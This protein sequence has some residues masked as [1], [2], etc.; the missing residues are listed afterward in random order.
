[1]FQDFRVAYLRRHV[2][3]REEL[4]LSFL[5]QSV[6]YL[7]SHSAKRIPH[8]AGITHFDVTNLVEYGEEQE[9]LS[10]LDDKALYK[11]SLRK[12]FSAFFLKAIAHGLHHVPT[13]NGFLDY[14]FIRNG[15]TLY[16]AEDVN[17][18][19][20]VHT[21]HGVVRP[22]LRNAHQ[23]DLQT[24]AGEMRDLTRRAR[25]TDP[26]WLY[27][28]AARIYAREAVRQ[29]DL[30]A[31]GGLW[32]LARSVF[33]SPKPD[34]ADTPEEKRLKPEE[35]LGSTS[36]LANIGMMVTGHQT[37]T[38]I[39]PPEVTMFGIGDLH[40]APRVVDGEVVPRWTITLCAT[41]DHRAFDAGE[42][43]PMYQHLKRYFENPS[44]I[45]DWKP[46]DEI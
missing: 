39:I 1:M 14:N 25:R 12:N 40:L 36:T 30:G 10:Q 34:F 20:T 35:V 19:F 37:M 6:S 26:D 16:K 13:L 28:E 18:S 38:V 15:G 9:T 27:R 11:R 45:Y 17:I 2:K 42:G 44:I 22:V 33:R 31:L 29:L 21:R 41:M 5:R 32:M 24:V 23:K 8:A 3:V 7:L 4:P 43:F 46:G